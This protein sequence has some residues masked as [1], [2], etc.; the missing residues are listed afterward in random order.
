M[1]R[2]I[3]KGAVSLIINVRDNLT[4]GDD[5][6]DRQRRQNEKGKEYNA[7]RREFVVGVS[8]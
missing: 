3:K 4:V 5:T 6:K 2:R 1:E 7:W 8:V